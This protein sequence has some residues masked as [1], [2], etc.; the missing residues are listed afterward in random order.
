[1][2]HGAEHIRRY[3][4]TNGQEGHLWL[5]GVPTLILTT[6]GRKSGQERKTALIY[7]QTEGRYVVVASDGGAAKHPN[8][9][10]NLLANPKVVVQVAADKFDATARTATREE[11]AAFWPL[12]AAV[13]PHYDDYE[14]KTT[15]EIPLVILEPAAA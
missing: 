4:E 12:M 2:L 3:E 6:R 9:Y 13:W 10:L 8:W 1:M 15:R 7:Q 14:R 5:N 11:R